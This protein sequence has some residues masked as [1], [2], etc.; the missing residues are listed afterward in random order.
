[1]I[2][3]LRSKEGEKPKKSLECHQKTTE[4]INKLPLLREEQLAQEADIACSKGDINSLFNTTRQFRDR[5]FNLNAL[6]KDK[7]WQCNFKN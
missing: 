1:M 2:H 5:R 6:V 4:K 3:G 7:N